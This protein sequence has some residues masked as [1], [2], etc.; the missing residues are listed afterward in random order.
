MSTCKNLYDSLSYDD[1]EE[2]NLNNLPVHKQKRKLMKKLREIEKLEQKNCFELTEEQKTKLSKKSAVLE[3]LE[4]LEHMNKSSTL[5]KKYTAQTKKSKPKVNKS[6]KPHKR[7]LCDDDD[8]LRKYQEIAKEE[9]ERFK[10]ETLRKEKER[11]RRKEQERILREEKRKK[12]REEKR[13]KEREENRKKLYTIYKDDIKFMG[14]HKYNENIT[15]Q[16][17]RKRY[18]KLCLKHH[19]DK[20][21]DQESFKRLNNV[22]TRLEKYVKEIQ[23]L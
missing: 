6:K 23:Q 21:G 19:P 14:L 3:Q 11:I 13:K 4:K 15:T 18:Y 20:G 7:K 17:L 9:N 16:F 8:I 22:N 12:E 1:D 5:K 10:E 2:Y